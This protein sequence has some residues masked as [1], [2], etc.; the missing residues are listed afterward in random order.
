MEH[1]A[2]TPRLD[3]VQVRRLESLLEQHLARVAEA[4]GRAVHDL[5]DQLVVEV[6]EEL[7]P[8]ERLARE[9]R[10]HVRHH[11]PRFHADA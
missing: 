9:T 10:L 1:E 11:A 4:L 3:D 5:G 7:A 6:T 2:D 8:A